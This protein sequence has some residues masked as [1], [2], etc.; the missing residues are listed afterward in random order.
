MNPSTMM[1]NWCEEEQV[2]G[3]NGTKPTPAITNTTS[4]QTHTQTILTHSLIQ[5]WP[6]NAPTQVIL[7]HNSNHTPPLPIPYHVMSTPTTPQTNTSQFQHTKKCERW[8][9]GTADGLE[10][11]LGYPSIGPGISIARKPLPKMPAHLSQVKH[12]KQPNTGPSQPTVI[13]WPN[14]NTNNHISHTH[15]LFTSLLNTPPL[16][17]HTNPNQKHS[18]QSQ[19]THPPYTSPLSNLLN[20]YK[21]SLSQISPHNSHLH[22]SQTKHTIIEHHFTLILDTT[23]ARS[24]EQARIEELGIPTQ[25]GAGEMD[26]EGVNEEDGAIEKR[27]RTGAQPLPSPDRSADAFEVVERERVRK[28]NKVNTQDPAP[29]NLTRPLTPEF[30]TTN[31]S[32]NLIHP[33]QPNTTTHFQ[34]LTPNFNNKPYILT[35]AYAERQEILETIEA[36]RGRNTAADL[37]FEVSTPTLSITTQ[38]LTHSP[39]HIQN[40]RCNKRHHSHTPTPPLPH[41]NHDNLQSVQATLH[42][43]SHTVHTYTQVNEKIYVSEAAKLGTNLRV[44]VFEPVLDEEGDMKNLVMYMVAKTIGDLPLEVKWWT[45][46]L[47]NNN[48]PIREEG[49]MA[50]ADWGELHRNALPLTQTKENHTI[51]SNTQELESTLP[52][53]PTSPGAGDRSTRTRKRKEFTAK[54]TRET[55]HAKNRE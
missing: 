46:R 15:S 55:K 49:E 10:R 7:K 9:V 51:Q 32:L 54:V 22:K 26:T 48:N 41:F 35:Q 38:L 16:T 50:L 40:A 27:R 28:Y 2:E 37:F 34:A 1:V 29:P 23:P 43:L 19:H 5:A 52:H 36:V 25:M 3:I 33:S 42:T 53:C 44:E 24:H 45:G 18:N 31:L 20:L 21:Q 17:Y 6:T 47:D 4:T 11:M 12:T 39:T 8:T 14:H 30:H 13:L